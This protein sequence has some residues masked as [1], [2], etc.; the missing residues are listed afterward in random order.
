MQAVGVEIVL[1][2]HVVQDDA[3]SRND[4]ARPLSVGNRRGRDVAVT[5][6]NAHVGRAAVGAHAP[7]NL[8]PPS[9]GQRAIER[10]ERL[11]RVL[12]P[13]GGGRLHHRGEA[14]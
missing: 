6:D 7:R 3:G 13:R 4:V 9:P 5:V 8:F 1:T 11:D 12:Q 10:P 2:E 14:A